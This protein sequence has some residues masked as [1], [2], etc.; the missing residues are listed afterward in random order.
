MLSF[1]NIGDKPPGPSNNT[2]VT[3]TDDTATA[4]GYYKDLLL[5]E[6]FIESFVLSSPEIYG[7]SF[8]LVWNAAGYKN[9]PKKS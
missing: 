2:I 7:L 6:I 8:N 3:I 4:P 9:R 1:V 5:P